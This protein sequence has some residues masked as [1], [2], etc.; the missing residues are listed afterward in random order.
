[1]KKNENEK[2]METERKRLRK[3][4][5][6][7][8]EESEKCEQRQIEKETEDNEIS[9]IDEIERMKMEQKRLTKELKRLR[10]E[11][12]MKQKASETEKQK[13]SETES[14]NQD[15]DK[16]ETETN[17]EKGESRKRYID[18][19]KITLQQLAYDL[20]DYEN[21]DLPCSSTGPSCSK[22]ANNTEIEETNE[23]IMK[24]ADR[25][26][27]ARE[28]QEQS[29]ADRI[30]LDVDGRHFATTR[31]TLLSTPDTLF[32]DIITPDRN[33]FFIDRDGAHFRFILNYLRWGR[34]M[35]IAIWPRETR[36]LL[37]L[38]NEC[39][40][41]RLDWLRRLVDQRLKMCR[42]LALAF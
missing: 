12:Q 11:K 20:S 22:S 41:Y 2:E 14:E 8:F 18:A 16:S 23:P 4:R 15:K 32:Q 13:A 34:Q 6:T 35:D 17:V 26:I 10:K 31:A 38:R 42:D 3:E 7:L 30:T 40:H 39:I 24:S 25:Q 28:D 33:H 29:Q 19:R 9:E 5:K 1:M 27:Q 21:D 36:Y 37:E